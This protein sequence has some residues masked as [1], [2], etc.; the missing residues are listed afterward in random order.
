MSASYEFW[1]TDDAGRRM[2]LLKDFT[3]ASFSRTTRGYGTIQFGLP[4]KAYLPYVPVIFQPDWRIDV[5]RSPAPAFPMR[6]EGSY[7][8]RKPHIYQKEENASD[9]IE[10]FGRSPIEILRRQLVSTAGDFTDYCDDGMKMLVT[11]AFASVPAPVG[12]FGID[13]DNSLGPT[14]YVT[15]K[16]QQNL[17]DV[18]TDLKNRSFQLNQEDSANR[19]IFFDCVEGPGLENGFGYIFRTFANRRGMDRTNGVVFSTANGNLKAP[20]YYEDY[21]EQITK[22]WVNGTIVYSNDRYLSRWN[23]CARFQTSN[24]SDPSINADEARQ[25]LVENGK[26]ISLTA[27]FLSTPGSK[28]QPRSLYGVDWDM[29]DT[30]RVF[31]ANKYFN[32]D[33]EIVWISVDENGQENIVGINKVGM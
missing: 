5:W 11:H 1:L 29:G 17:L 16:I 13:G 22:A 30:V 28:N 2:V 23:T 14:L 4:M 3:F 18:L 19:K 6:R 9:M 25:M 24:I 32:V 33:V 15:N 7:W 26:D 12:E 10:F 27:N 8:L 21:L 31:Y 20:E